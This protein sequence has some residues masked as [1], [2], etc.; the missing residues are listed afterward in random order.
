[1]KTY[2]AT[3]VFTPTKPAKLTF[4]ERDELNEQLVD[5]LRTPGKQVV[6]YG[7]SKSGKT[8]LLVNKLEQLYENHITTKCTADTSF[9]N[10]LLSAFDKLNP[11]YVSD[12][13]ESR[14]RTIKS[15][16]KTDYTIIKAN[17]EANLTSSNQKNLKR[18]IPPQLTAERLAE[19]MGEAG[20]CWVLEDFHKVNDIEKTKISQIMKVFMDSANEYDSIK[21]IAV[22]AVDTARQV[23]EYDNEME[24][25]VSEILVPLMRPDLLMQILKSGEDLLNFTIQD[26]IKQ[27]IA[28]YASGL[29]SVCHQLCLNICFAANIIETCQ[30]KFIIEGE[31]LKSAIERYIKDTSDSLKS[32][33]DQALIR[34]RERKYDNCKIILENLTILGAEG[35]THNKLLTEIRKEIKDY[36]PSNLTS[37]L[38]ELSSDKRGEL[39]RY[40]PY[41]N[42]Y[43]FSDPIYLAYAQCLFRPEMS[44]DE[45]GITKSEFF[46]ILDD[47]IENYVGSKLKKIAQIDSNGSDDQLSFPLE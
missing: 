6:L 18:I 28:R 43:Y 39:L 37:Y 5:S 42:K 26:S 29:A 3:D 38:K 10:L 9:E 1:M 15:S 34:K 36:P 46:Q 45:I 27:E 8:T 32:L 30:E 41:S 11:F 4:I 12:Y 40:D 16:I 33:F 31:H 17:I 24:H 19:F 21:I 47:F 25:R 23:I 13:S 7:P 22:G 44:K 35:A 14:S 2:K 20:C